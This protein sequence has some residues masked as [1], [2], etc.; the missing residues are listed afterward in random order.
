[1]RGRGAHEKRARRVDIV[2]SREREGQPGKRRAAPADRRAA[3]VRAQG[4]LDRPGDSRSRAGRRQRQVAAVFRPRSSRRRGGARLGRPLRAHAPTPA[5]STPLP[6]RRRPTPA[7]DDC[8]RVE[9]NLLD[10]RPALVGRRRLE[11]A[12]RAHLG[13]GREHARLPCKCPQLLRGRESAEAREQP[14]DDVDLCLGERRVEPDAAHG[15]SMPARRLE[16][17]ASRCASEVRVVEDDPPRARG[18]LVASAPASS[19][20]DPPRSSRLSR[21]WPR[22]TYSS[23]T[24]LL[25]AP[26]MPMTTTTSA[27]FAARGC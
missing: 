21:R 24:R 19:R 6:R 13:G 26:G 23:A 27:P 20:K 22:A 15:G 5:A 3:A 7:R 14:L 9:G 8:V 17:M 18:Q 2:R 12:E 25:P 11:L 1:M 4:V 16:H 10:A